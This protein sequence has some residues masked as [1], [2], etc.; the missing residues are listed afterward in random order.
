M[1]LPEYESMYL[2]EDKHWWFVGRQKLALTLIDEWI[3]LN[4]NA[5]ILDV[6]C[7]TGGNVNALSRYGKA[8]GVDISPIA[9]AF[10]RRR[11]LPYLLQGSGLT[12][13]YTNATFDLVT[14]FDVLYHRWITDDAQALQEFYRVLKP[15]GWLLITDSAL[16][17]LWSTHD[18]VYFARQ[19]YTL[20]DL[21][22]KLEA[23]G[24]NQQVGSYANFLLLPAFL[25]ARLTIDWLPLAN[26]IDAQGTFPDWFNK[27]LTHVRG[28][29]A[30]W[31]R[32]GGTLPVGSSLIC[33]ARKPINEIPQQ[34]G[35]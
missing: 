5:H 17:I 24:F 22:Q 6:G 16:P 8:V 9:L 18:E 15:G 35:D 7:G 19:R 12:L 26:N 21:R 3:P 23:A 20:K 13:P 11:R 10:A 2:L 31:M 1:E 33:L 30:R 25:F 4:P 32:R 29:E 14:I 28:L 34:D 27:L